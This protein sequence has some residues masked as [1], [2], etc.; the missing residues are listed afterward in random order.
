M[1]EDF[2][3]SMAIKKYERVASEAIQNIFI[4]GSMF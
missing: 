3:K 4:R 2:G 1:V